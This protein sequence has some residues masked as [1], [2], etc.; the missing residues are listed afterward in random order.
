MKTSSNRPHQSDR[1]NAVAAIVRT[2]PVWIIHHAVAAITGP[3]R[4][5]RFQTPSMHH[6]DEDL[7]SLISGL[8]EGKQ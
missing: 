2:N 8:G 3:N 1:D 7:D 4:W 6:H 5:Y